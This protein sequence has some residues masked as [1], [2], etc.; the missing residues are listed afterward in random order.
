MSNEHPAGH[1]SL[2]ADAV[3]AQCGTVNA[4]GVFIC[5]V[6][7]NNL[8]DQRAIRLQAEQQLL[9][10]V[11]EESA[12]GGVGLRGA[13]GMVGILLI[14]ITMFNVDAI[15]AWLV[16][17]QNPRVDPLR[18]LWS[19]VE[20]PAYDALIGPLRADPPGLDALAAAR[21]VYT[22][23]PLASGRYAVYHDGL[24]VGAAALEVDGDV[25]R[26]GALLDAGAEVRGQGR[27][28]PGARMQVPWDSAAVQVGRALYSAAGAAVQ[29]E[30]GV[31][32]C[33]GRSDWDENHYVFYLH[34]LPGE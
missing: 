25:V 5:R 33:Y 6:C 17:I 34:R 4:E 7:G 28:L 24:A 21:S 20:A 22:S 14:L 2:G 19:G 31:I 13:L 29:Q 12:G 32:E 8:R 11:G 10:H 1:E 26:F 16:D 9:E 30:D 23:G 15:S 3:C 18:P 27:M